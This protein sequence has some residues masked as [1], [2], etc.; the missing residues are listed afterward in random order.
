MTKN[1]NK[2][3][4]KNDRSFIKDK[5]SSGI[6]PMTLELQPN[7]PNPFNIFTNIK[8]NIPETG[9]V[10]LMIYNIQGQLMRALVDE[11]QKSGEHTV[12]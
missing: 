6:I 4:I 11:T 12:L 1:G 10:L 9:A 2:L 7:Y 3:N 8:Y 5:N